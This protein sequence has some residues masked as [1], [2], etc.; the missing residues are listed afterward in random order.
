MRA[1]VLAGGKGERLRP[2]TD[3]RPKCMVELNGRPILWY[4][5]NW[6]ISHGCKKITICC[7]YLHDVIVEYFGDGTEYGVEISYQIEP[8]PL[9]RGGALKLAMQFDRSHQPVI[10]LNGDV[11]TKLRVDDLVR[12]HRKYHALATVVAVPFKSQFGIIEHNEDGFVSAFREKPVLPY[13]INAGIYLLEPQMVE[14]LPSKGDH[15]EFTFPR[16]AQDGLLKSYRTKDFW[17]AV[18]TVKDLSEL[19]DAIRISGLSLLEISSEIQRVSGCNG[20]VDAV[21]A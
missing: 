6:L 16:L 9:G 19:E 17:H 7:G 20:S 8:E 11:L 1:I 21:K 10:A 5:V 13:W 15:E 14:L 4:N 12:H 2:L 3:C 18:D